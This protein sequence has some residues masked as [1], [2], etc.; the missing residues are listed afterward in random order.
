MA[1]PIYEL[2]TWG[3]TNREYFEIGNG[4]IQ[5]FKTKFITPVEWGATWRCV[6]KG[7][8]IFDRVSLELILEDTLPRLTGDDYRTEIDELIMI[9]Q[10][11][12]AYE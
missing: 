10:W 9:L 8:E 4:D 12:H 7:V 6:I 3:R 5:I 1:E 2:E 11:E